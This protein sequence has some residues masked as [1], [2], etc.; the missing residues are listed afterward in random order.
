[1]CDASLSELQKNSNNMH[2]FVLNSF[3][4]LGKVASRDQE[5]TV[6]HSLVLLK[7]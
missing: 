7:H 2:Y 1:M 6:Y 5:L 3:F 4:H